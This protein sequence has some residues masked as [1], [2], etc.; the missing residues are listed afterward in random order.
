MHPRVNR[1]EDTRSTLRR[2]LAGGGRVTW[3]HEPG[4]PVAV[5]CWPFSQVMHAYALSD[6]VSGPARFPGLARGLAGYRDPRGGYRESIGRGKRYYDDNAWIGLAFLQRHAFSGGTASRRRAADIDEFVQTGL[7]ETSGAI[8]W[9]EDGDTL[10]ACSTGAGALL[11]AELG[12]DVRESLDFLASLRDSDGLVR[13]HVRADGSIEPSI[14]SYNQGLLISAAYSAGD[15]VLA[16]DAAEA[17]AAHFT[18][19]RLWRQ[20]VCFNAVYVKALLRLGQSASIREYADMLHDTGRDQAGW[21]TRAG[22]YDEGAVLDTAGALQIF[23]L[24]EFPHLIERV[25]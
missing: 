11:H 21:F 20:A 23:T 2:S 18:P 16:L 7:D 17:G 22:R 9:V 5:T 8:R 14:Y 4:S 12:G 24:L 1:Y 6:S 10:N 3:V 25:V 15:A 13:D 19:A